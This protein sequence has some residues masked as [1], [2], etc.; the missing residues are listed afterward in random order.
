M[1][2][3]CYGN[4]NYSTNGKSNETN[5]SYH[6]DFPAESM[7][8]EISEERDKERPESMYNEI[9]DNHDTESLENIYNDI[10]DDLE[11]Y[12]PEN[13]FHET[14]DIALDEINN[15]STTSIGLTQPSM[16][17]MDN[18]VDQRELNAQKRKRFINLVK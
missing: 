1:L 11:K 18:L 15:I 13:L 7:Y 8:N 10:S 6:L 3:P 16:Y 17:V 12:S 9:R 14:T 2:A 4:S 5:P